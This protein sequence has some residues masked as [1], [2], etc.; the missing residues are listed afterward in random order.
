MFL[1][2]STIYFHIPVRIITRLFL[3]H[4]TSESLEGRADTEYKHTCH[5]TMVNWIARLFTKIVVWI[6]PK[7]I[8]ASA[9]QALSCHNGPC[10]KCVCVWLHWTRGKWH[11][12]SCKYV[13]IKKQEIFCDT[14]PWPACADVGYASQPPIPCHVPIQII[15][16]Q[17]SSAWAGTPHPRS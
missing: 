15:P 8:I 1:S 11:R 16:Q 17:E 9:A 7:W 6:F 2:V 14:P 5:R 10:S 3:I 12:V 13:Q 4:F